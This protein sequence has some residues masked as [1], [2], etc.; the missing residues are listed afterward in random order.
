MEEVRGFLKGLNTDINPMNQGDST[1]RDAL[2]VVQ[3]SEEGN[4]YAL[5]NEQGTINQQV[6][7]P[8]GFKYIGHTVLDS[9]IHQGM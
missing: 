4:I 3:V 5:T 7:F 8:D 1:Y 9:E 6:T 2:N